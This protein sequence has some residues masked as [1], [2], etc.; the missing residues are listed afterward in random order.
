M[1]NSIIFDKITTIAC[2]SFI[3]FLD[4]NMKKS[5]A[6][7]SFLSIAPLP[8]L[9][10]IR[11]ESAV[12]LALSLCE[13]LSLLLYS[14]HW[15]LVLYVLSQAGLAG[16]TGVYALYVCQCLEDQKVRG[17]QVMVRLS[18]GAKL[19]TLCLAAV[20]A[21]H[22]VLG[23]EEMVCAASGEMREC[24]KSQPWWQVSSAALC[25]EALFAACS[26]AVL[27]LLL[28]HIAKAALELRY[29]SLA[30]YLEL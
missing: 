5:Q 18:L 11:Q 8:C 29:R 23:S 28:R 22:K 21:A 10:L 12:L 26:C 25:F 20:V 24:W 7:F 15:L 4:Y 6:A 14:P 1:Q 13:A 27:L 2:E 9:S 19:L 16:C 30:F 3:D 17:V